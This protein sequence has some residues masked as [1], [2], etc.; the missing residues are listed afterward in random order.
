MRPTRFP[1][2]QSGLKA[3][4]AGASQT[5]FRGFVLS[6]EE[7]VGQETKPCRCVTDVSRGETEF[8]TSRV[9]VGVGHEERFGASESGA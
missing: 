8:L 4:S 7:V 2:N 5:W 9:Y 1:R 6:L 3:T